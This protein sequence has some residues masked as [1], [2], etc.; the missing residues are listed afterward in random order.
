MATGDFKRC[1]T[2]QEYGWFNTTFMAHHC[3]PAW[4]CRMK[5]DDDDC[6]VRVYARDEEEAAEK[7]ADRHDCDS[8]EYGICSGRYGAGETIVLVRKADDPA[9]EASL[10]EVEGE[11]VPHY[12]ARR[13][14]QSEVEEAAE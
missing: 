14:S 13:V 5:T 2:C 1:P 3:K 6:W 10:W 11:M 9:R 8:G 7:F 12:R 4:E